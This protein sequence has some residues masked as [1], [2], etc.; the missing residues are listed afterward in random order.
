MPKDHPEHYFSGKISRI[1]ITGDRVEER[2]VIRG[3]PHGREVQGGHETLPHQPNGLLFRDGML[4]QTVG[5]TSSTGGTDNWGIGEQPLSACIIEVDYHRIEGTLDV[6]PAS[7]FDPQ[8]P[9]SLVRI[10]ASGVRN[11]LELVEHTN[12]HLYTAVNMNDRQGPV[13]GVPDHPDIHGDQNVL[14][15]QRTP[16]HEALYILERGR[17]YGC[18]NVSRGH[19]VL[20][21]G[22][23]TEGP[24]PYEISDYPVGTQPDEGF[25]PELMYPIWRWGGTSPNGMI[26]YLPEFAHP[27]KHT[28]INCF[29]SANKL[30]VMTLGSDGLPVHMAALEDPQGN[31]LIYAGPL[32]VT[33]DPQTGTLYI[34]SFGTQRLFGEDGVMFM[35][36]PSLQGET[37]SAEASMTV[38][39]D[40]QLSQRDFGRKVYESQCLMCHQQQGEGLAGSFPPL[41]GSEWVL[42]DKRLGINIVLGGLAG[43]IE[44]KGEPYDSIMAPWGAVLND[45]QVA[46]VLTYI[47]SEWG[48]DASAVSPEEVATER[49]AHGVRATMWTGE[50]LKRLFP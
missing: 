30:A 20:N 43:P 5:S 36:R 14:V 27:L 35:L 13:N 47:R 15:N 49:A 8:Q 3:L 1:E 6:R 18:P 37:L 12:G 19:Y 31:T 48:N 24:D 40:N 50:E 17:H 7:G 34:A 33:A 23:P 22:N 10:Y 21:G 41:E 42:G 28:L 46:A 2:I 25:A 16:D 11:A 9:D 29:Y 44:V 45:E 38:A 4:Y 39:M 32:D 26:E